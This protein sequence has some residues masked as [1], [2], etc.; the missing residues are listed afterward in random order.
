[1]CLAESWRGRRF[2]YLRDDGRARG[3]SPRKLLD[4][5][6]RVVEYY[7]VVGCLCKC[8]FTRIL[9]GDVDD[10]PPVVGS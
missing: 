5:H 4:L 9:E 3:M 2:G 1:M 8:L 10:L 6:A 7:K